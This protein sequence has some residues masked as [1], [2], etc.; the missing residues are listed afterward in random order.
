MAQRFM[1][2]KRKK[3][4][5]YRKPEPEVCYACGSDLIERINVRLVGVIRVCKSCKEQ[6]V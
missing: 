1:E 4:R 6:Q 2:N 5:N 3:K